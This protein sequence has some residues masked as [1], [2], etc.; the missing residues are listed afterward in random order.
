MRIDPNFAK[1][2]VWE[3]GYFYA[4]AAQQTYERAVDTV[5]I[6]ER[7]QETEAG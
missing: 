1:V 3:R 5:F 7:R 2:D 4:S 6:L